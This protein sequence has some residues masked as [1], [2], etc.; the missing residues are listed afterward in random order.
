MVFGVPD[1]QINP[2]I[3]NLGGLPLAQ[4]LHAISDK[5][6]MTRLSPVEGIV[7]ARDA[8]PGNLNDNNDVLMVIAP[9]DFLFGWVNVHEADQARVAM[10]QDMEIRFPMEASFSPSSMRTSKWSQP[11]CR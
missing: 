10:G 2:L 7:I 1:D 6:K 4:E 11:E 8:V 3:Q 9:L 5:A